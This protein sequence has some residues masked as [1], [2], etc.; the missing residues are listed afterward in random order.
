MILSDQDKDMHYEFQLND[1]VLL[2]KESDSW[3]ELPVF[4]EDPNDMLPGN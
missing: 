3:R 1:H 4:K 2:D